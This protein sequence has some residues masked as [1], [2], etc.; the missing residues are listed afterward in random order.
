MAAT[1]TKKALP[2]MKLRPRRRTRRAA[3]AAG[4]RD[5]AQL[6][7]RA[8]LDATAAVREDAL[9]TAEWMMSRVTDRDYQAARQ[10]RLD[11]LATLGRAHAVL[12]AAIRQV[13]TL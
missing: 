11:A 4:L 12:T 9:V 13:E 3:I 10:A 8:A 1:P 2:M 7:E 5:A 6:A